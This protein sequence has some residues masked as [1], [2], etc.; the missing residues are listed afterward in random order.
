ME[1]AKR[2]ALTGRKWRVGLLLPALMACGQGGVPGGGAP[3][4]LRLSTEPAGA[5]IRINGEQRGVSG[6]STRPLN[7]TLS[8]GAYQ[9]EA[10]LQRDAL[11]VWHGRHELTVTAGQALAPVH[12]VLARQLTPEG[13]ASARSEQERL[14]TLHERALAQFVAQ[15]DGTVHQPEAGLVWMRCSL[16]QTWTGSEC[17]GEAQRLSHAQAEKAAAAVEFAGQHDWRLPTQPELLALVYCSSGMRHQPKSDGMGGGCAGD[18]RSPTVL[19][20]VFPNTPAG[21]FWSSTPNERFAFSAWGV[22]FNTGH[23]GTG[24]RTEYVHARLVRHAD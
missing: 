20:S 5:S 12:L 7:L 1:T 24:G 14:N 3:G 11:A 9:I 10:E 16:G 13:E 18:Y 21:N 2:L 17:T 19:D 4:E 8:P 23:T 6:D 22:S 15:D